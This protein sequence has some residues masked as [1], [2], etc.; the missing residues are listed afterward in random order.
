MTPSLTVVVPIH[1]EAEFLPGAL[2]RLLAALDGV[3][4]TSTVILAENGSSDD[5][6]AVA[7]RLA[8][9]D[10]RVKVL[11]LPTPDYGAAMRHGFLAANTDWVANVDIDYFSGEFLTEAIGLGDEA[12]V[13]LASKRAPGA[14]DRRGLVRRLGT[15]AFNVLLR[16]L[17]RS[18]VS[19]THGMKVIRGSVVAAVAPAVISTKDL[20]DTELVIRAERARYRIREIPAVVEEIRQTRSSLIKRVPRT[21]RGLLRIRRA[22][23]DE[24]RTAR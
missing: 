15:L 20:F 11:H 17:L 4:A 24:A 14:E 18:R 8:M 2:T 22:L 13:V 21:V 9:A 5:T 6:A 19:D 7:N 23:A 10:R 1:N 12:D 3:A 16:V